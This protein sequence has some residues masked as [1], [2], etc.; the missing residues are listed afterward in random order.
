MVNAHWIDWTEEMDTNAYSCSLC[1]TLIMLEDG[2]PQ[3]ND[4][5]FCPCCGAKMDDSEKVELT[6][7]ITIEVTM[8]QKVNANDLVDIINDDKDTRAFEEQIKKALC[9]DDVKVTANQNFILSK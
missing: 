5:Y 9:A 8:I 1:N 7:V 6:K 4:Y 2:T 3:E